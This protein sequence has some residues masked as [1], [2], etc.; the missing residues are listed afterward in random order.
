MDDFDLGVL[1]QGFF[2][3]HF[4]SPINSLEAPTTEG[5]LLKFLDGE[6]AASITAKT[7]L[8]KIMHHQKHSNPP[9]VNHVQGIN[10]P[11]N[12]VIALC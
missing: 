10:Q 7:C 6:I 1:P 2:H 8:F 5:A 4:N 3:R 12:A 11:R 9:L